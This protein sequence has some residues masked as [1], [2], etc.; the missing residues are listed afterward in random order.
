FG[1]NVIIFSANCLEKDSLRNEPTKTAI[2]VIFFHSFMQLLYHFT[3][4][5]LFANGKFTAYDSFFTFFIYY[6]I[7]CLELL[8]NTAIFL[9]YKESLKE[10]CTPFEHP[11]Y[12][13]HLAFLL[14][15]FFA[16]LNKVKR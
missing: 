1:N 8:R 9:F 7:P 2:F 13:E 4:Y 14:F 10:H 16:A 11:S 6:W 5:N 3:L 12:Q 15:M